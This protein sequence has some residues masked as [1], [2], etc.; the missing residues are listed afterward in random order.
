MGDPIY[1]VSWYDGTYVLP[2]RPEY[3]ILVQN[4]SS[5]FVHKKLSGDDSAVSGAAAISGDELFYETADF[6][7]ALAFPDQRIQ[8]RG[9]IAS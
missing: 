3:K 8:I 7:T 4:T 5:I 2:A 6:F 1:V 9:F